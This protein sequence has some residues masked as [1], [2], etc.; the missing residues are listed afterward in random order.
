MI[1]MP[2]AII[3]DTSHTKSYIP[4]L[5]KIPGFSPV[6][7]QF[8][9][10]IE[11]RCIHEG[12]FVD[13]LY[14]KSNG[15]EL[16][17]TNVR[18]NCLFEINEPIVSRFILNFYSQVKVQ[19]DE[20]GY[21]LISFM[22]QHE[23]ITLSLAQFGQILR[24][25]YNGQAFF[26]NEWDLASLAYSQETKGPYHTDLPTP[27]D[28]RQFLQL[29]RVEQDMKHW[30][31]LI[32]ENVFELGGHRNHLSASLAHMLY[33]I[34]AEEQ[35][36]LAYFFVQQ[37]ECARATSTANHPYGMF[38]THLYRHVM[39]HY[40]HLDN[41]IYN[42]VDRVMRPLALKQTREPQSD[43]GK[44]R[45][46]V[47]STSAHHNYGSSSHQGDNDEDDGDSRASTPSPTT[48]LNSL[49]PLYY[50]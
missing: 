24:I 16:M 50:Q 8:Y 36:N 35:Y 26:T 33:C 48:Y 18:F 22:I 41:G 7:A 13:Q 32:R 20:Y 37:I 21:I 49:Q 45:Y 10:P 47:S 19:T 2:R 9:K 30:E 12:R 31:E 46:I 4:K 40:S 34:I 28:I 14:Y 1:N 44:A 17:F 15:I 42:V 43:H 39:E 29:D 23:F 27:D 3:G 5:S 11:N 6:L 38:L 25:P